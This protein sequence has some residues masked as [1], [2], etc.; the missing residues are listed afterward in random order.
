M[1]MKNH[2]HPARLA[3]R[4]RTIFKE[5]CARLLTSVNAHAA[6][7]QPAML[8]RSDKRENNTGLFYTNF[9]NTS[10]HPVEHR[11]CDRPTVR[12]V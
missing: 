3:Y 10:A 1:R 9:R 7:N 11:D 2:A 12:M 6:L 4:M 5:N 8:G